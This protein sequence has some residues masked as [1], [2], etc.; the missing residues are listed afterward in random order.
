MRYKKIFMLLLLLA[1][2]CGGMAQNSIDNIISQFSSVGQSKFTSVVE[3]DPGTRKIIKVIKVLEL[4]D[5]DAQP[6]I[7]S[8]RNEARHG[9]FSEKSDGNGK[10]LTLTTQN[11]SQNRVYMLVCNGP[12]SNREKQYYNKMKITIIVKNN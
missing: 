9:D 6:F 7:S 5:R 8:F 10:V 1:S 2:A 11:R 3:R 4:R 12:Y